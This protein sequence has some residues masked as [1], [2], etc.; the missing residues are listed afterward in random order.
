M[1]RVNNK[2]IRRNFHIPSFGSFLQYIN[3]KNISEHH[4]KRVLLYDANKLCLLGKIRNKKV[5]LRKD[6][7]LEYEGT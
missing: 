4:R 5:Y 6:I 7:F 2:Q 1:R 3:G